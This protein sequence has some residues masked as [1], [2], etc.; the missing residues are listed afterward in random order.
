M[1]TEQIIINCFSHVAYM[2][3]NNPNPSQPV[4]PNSQQEAQRE[5]SELVET[6]SNGNPLTLDEY[7]NMQEENI[8]E[9]PMTDE[10]IVRLIEGETPASNE[11][12]DSENDSEEG[13][14]PI[15]PYSLSE[16]IPVCERLLTTLE[17]HDGFTEHDYSPLRAIIRKIY[18][19]KTKNHKQPT[20]TDYFHKVQ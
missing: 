18:V 9:E 19:A 8:T 16:A 7:L 6:A 10:D 2:P 13:P 17:S 1:V 3:T 5:L 11:D 15:Q 12:H 4:E 20:L 14:P